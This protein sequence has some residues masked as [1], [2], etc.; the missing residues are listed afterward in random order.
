MSH[1]KELF[2]GVYSIDG[3]IATVNLSKG[4][5]VYGE[6]LIRDRSI[7][8]RLWNPYRSKLAAAMLKGLKEFRIKRNSR[9][10]YL[11]AATGTTA[12]HVSDIAAEG[13]VFCVEFSERNM[14]ELIKVCESRKNMMPILSDANNV[15]EYEDLIKECDIIYQDVSTRD[16]SGMLKKNSTILK[17]GSYT[18]FIIK[19]QSI[20]I[21][22]RPEL[23]FKEELSNL[24]EIFEVKEKID[25]EPYDSL[26]LFSVLVKK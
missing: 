2:E 19:S 3:K 8:Y 26:H 6:E 24:S 25:L 14:R 15:E 21:A 1:I 5:K 22:K 10:L 4:V 18:Y 11:G 17:H 20:D 16:Q 9:V 23:I 13:E 12:S 7:E